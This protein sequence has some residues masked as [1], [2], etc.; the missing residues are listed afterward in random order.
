MHGSQRVLDLNTTSGFEQLLRDLAPQV[1]SA[2]VRRY[3]NFD[4]CEDAVQEALLAAAVEWKSQGVPA[5]PRG[6]LIT[7]AFAATDR[8]MAEGL[9]PNASRGDRRGS[10]AVGLGAC[11]RCR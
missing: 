8:T 6:W 7:V 2:L 5:N 3:G 9:G 1:L 4:S 11:T 10:G